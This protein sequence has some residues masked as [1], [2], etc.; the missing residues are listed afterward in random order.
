MQY[1]KITGIHSLKPIFKPTFVDSY[2]NY[3]GLFIFLNKNINT[4]NCNSSK[5]RNIVLYELFK[6]EQKATYFRKHKHK[7]FVDYL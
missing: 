4:F 7:E 5:F 6:T 1:L 2:I 3:R